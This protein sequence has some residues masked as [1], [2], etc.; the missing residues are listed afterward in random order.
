MTLSD[1]FLDS[2][3]AEFDDANTIGF[4]LGGSHVRGEANPYSDVDIA[5][6]VAVP[7]SSDAP[8][9]RMVFRGGHLISLSTKTVAEVRADLCRPQWAIW[10]APSISQLHI[11]RDKDGTLAALVSEAQTFQW[12]PLQEAANRYASEEI[13]DLAEEAH[14][15]I[16][17]LLKGDE[18]A[19]LL[20]IRGLLSGITRLVAV[21]HGLM[22]KAEATYF[23]QVW[24]AMGEGSAWTRD[25]RIAI[26]LEIIGSSDMP[27]VIGSGLAALRLYCETVRLLQAILLPEHR[28]VADTT[29]QRIMQSGLL[30]VNNER[31]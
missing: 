23:P 17:A 31:R 6:F 29:V 8:R 3:V 12:S 30:R 28:E 19:V 4:A 22:L 21:K 9:H 7:P 2:L 11:L 13:A 10:V 15:I 1:D 18:Q 24:Q 27:P 14:K 25:H 16:A 20:F 26:G 5:R